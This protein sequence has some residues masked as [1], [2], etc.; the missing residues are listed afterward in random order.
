MTLPESVVEAAAVSYLRDLGYAYAHG[1]DLSPGGSSP[2]RSSYADVI[3]EPRLRAALAQINPHLP[4][5][6]LDTV[7]KQ[8]LRPESPSLLENNLAFQNNLTRGITVQIRKDGATRGDQAWLVDFDNPANNDWLVVGQLTIKSPGTSAHQPR[9]P[10]LIVFLNGMPIAVLELKK[11]TDTKATLKT[12]F[13]QLQ[14]YKNDIPALFN[15]NELLVVSDGTAAQVGSLTA[16]FER[17]SP[18]RTV[19]GDDLAPPHTPQM[20]TLLRGMFDKAR[21]LD[22][23]RNFILWETKD[24]LVKKIAGYHQFHAVNRAVAHTLRASAPKSQAPSKSGEPRQGDRRIGVVWHTQG[25]GKSI[26]MAI[27]A[28]KLIREP[29]MENPTIVVLTDRNDLDGQLFDQF[30]AADGLLPTPEQAD[31]RE[32]LRELLSVASGGVV[33]TTIQ[34]FGTKKGEAYPELSDRRNIVVVA[35]EAHRSQYE[36]VEGFARNIR[37]ALP[38]ASFIGFTGTPIESDDRSTVAVFGQEIHRYPVSQAVEDGA[39]VSLLYEARMARI[40]LPDDR[41]PVVDEDFAEVTE[42]EEEAA[43]GKLKSRWARLEAMVG[44]DQRLGLI[45]KDLLEHFDR[46]CEVVPGKAMFV[47]MSRRIAVALYQ[48]IIELRPEWGAEDDEAGGIKVVMTVKSDEPE[49]YQKHRRVKTQLKAI[50]NRFKDPDDPLRMVIVRDMWLTG[51]N[52]PCAHTLYVDKPMKGHGFMQAIARVNRVFKD[53]P[54]GLV[55]D[56]LGLAEPLRE[57]VDK[58]SGEGEDRPVAPPIEEALPVLEEKF[59]IVKDM[60]H[61]HDYAGYFSTDPKAQLAS[62]AKAAD[63]ICGRDT[64]PLTNEELDRLVTIFAQWTHPSATDYVPIP[65]KNDKQ[66]R[67]RILRLMSFLATDL[68]T[69]DDALYDKVVDALRAL[70]AQPAPTGTKLAG[71]N[72]QLALQLEPFMRKLFVKVAPK[73]AA[74][75]G[76]GHVGLG[77]LITHLQKADASPYILN[78]PKKAF[79]AR[80]GA[81]QWSSLD[82]AIRDT[83]E[84]RLD[85]A[86]RSTTPSPGLWRSVMHVM[87]EFLRHNDDKL[88]PLPEVPVG[89]REGRQR[90]L[91][92]M[93]RLNVAVGIAMHHEE[94]RWMRDEVGLFQ[95][96]QGLLLKNTVG[97]SGKT[98]E[99]LDAAV[100]QIV[101]KAVTSDEVIDIFD[102]AGIPKPDISILSDEFLENVKKS[103]LKNLQIEMLRKL[104]ADEI[105]SVGNRNVVQGRKFSEMLDRTLKSYQN[106]TLDAADVILQL[107]EHGREMQLLPNKGAELG[108]T[109]DEMAFYDALV[110]HGGVKEVM[111]DDVLGKIAKDLVAAIRRSVTIDWTQKE[112][113]RADMRR[114]VKKLLKRHG[115]PPDKAEAALVT[116]IEQAEHVCKDWATAS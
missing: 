86:H 14:T 73:E 105:K 95:G 9:R 101:S 11:P 84:A 22:Y 104:L 35:D 114:K 92:A 60:F 69:G 33:F 99:E 30:A 25:A 5:D 67:N 4:A 12:A 31:S 48:K 75:L 23:I 49:A 78:L 61:G 90:F 7:A 27:Y 1:P 21:L 46:R 16:G 113:V 74:S 37:D 20:D 96:V 59:Q 85:A 38:N 29:G 97:G 13:H 103:P 53:K 6:I 44:T 45:A 112:A 83:M 94:A 8:I 82:H 87:L 93:R 36:F 26:A 15:T 32:N 42:G 76:A 77:T 58:Y 19:D 98:E 62:L 50:E 116:V 10:D 64:A 51:F 28:A 54:N 47:C 43:K 68:G 66:T 89:S 39:I 41:K 52:A 102:A 63:F 115:Y 81:D 111:K 65:P 40:D 72:D 106:R 24:G 56:Y 18:W 71:H 3:L 100:G 2:E 55:V 108:L 80:D 70:L 109:E 110:D 79:I 17:F 88:G 34:K 57:A 107:I 91:D